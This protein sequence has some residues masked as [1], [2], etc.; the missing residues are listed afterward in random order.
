MASFVPRSFFKSREFSGGEK[1]EKEKSS[2]LASCEES[3]EAFGGGGCFPPRDDTRMA[4][5]PS[6]PGPPAPQGPT[7]EMRVKQRA[8]KTYFAASPD[9]K[10]LAHAVM[11]NL[12]LHEPVTKLIVENV[13]EEEHDSQD[14]YKM[15][16][17]N[18]KAL[19]K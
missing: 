12:S 19:G 11:S 16:E 15:L 17:D 1:E 8:V 18:A 14:V 3:C 4:R 10:P 7:M 6:A 13:D 2:C 5:P 9:S